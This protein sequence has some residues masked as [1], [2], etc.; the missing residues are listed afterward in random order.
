M[1][2]KCEKCNKESTYGLGKLNHYHDSLHGRTK[3]ATCKHCFFE[4]E[5]NPGSAIKK[6]ELAK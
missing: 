3:T 4:N 1:K 5:V 6:Q 2:I